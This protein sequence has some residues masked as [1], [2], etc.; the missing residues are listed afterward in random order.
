VQF[1]EHLYSNSAVLRTLIGFAHIA[2]LVIGGG[3]A[4]VADR[5]TLRAYRRGEDRGAE[6]ATI[7]SAHRVVIGGL[8]VVAVSGV[9]LLAADLDTYLHSRIFWI[10]MGLVAL[11]L[12]NG[13][14]LR[15]F[16]GSA[17]A[18]DRRWRQLAYAAGVS[19]SLWLLTTLTGAALP[20]VG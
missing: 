19:L 9:L 13:A 15:V 18:D 1:W 5:A 10:K 4:I 12:I 7:R 11:L 2:G 14:A 3:M 20:N 16:A 6:L 8:A 17:E